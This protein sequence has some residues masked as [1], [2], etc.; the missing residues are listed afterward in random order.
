MS[1]LGAL[2]E[3]S[4]LSEMTPFISNI[5]LV[6]LQPGT[7]ARTGPGPPPLPNSHQDGGV[8]SHSEADIWPL[9]S[10]RG[11]GDSHESKTTEYTYCFPFL[12]NRILISRFNFKL[13]PMSIC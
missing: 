4:P 12:S 13:K 7:E 10:T 2:Q 3:S 8:S 9:S 1:V 6:R 11:T 5:N